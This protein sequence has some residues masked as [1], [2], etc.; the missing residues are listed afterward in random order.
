MSSS[1]RDE[2]D[3]RVN[4]KFLKYKIFRFSKLYANKKQ[5]RERENE[6]FLKTGC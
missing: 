3:P 2:Q 6:F 4:W 1:F 5:K